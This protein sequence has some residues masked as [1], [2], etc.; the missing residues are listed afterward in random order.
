M[1]DLLEELWFLAERIRSHG[2]VLPGES[3]IERYVYF[4]NHSEYGSDCAYAR[5]SK[6]LFLKFDYEDIRGQ[7]KKIMELIDLVEGKGSR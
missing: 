6:D 7:I 1:N 5:K 2:G 3:M 4:K